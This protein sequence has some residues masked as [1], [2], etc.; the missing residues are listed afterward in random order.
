MGAKAETFFGI[1]GVGDLAT[2]CFSPT[3]RNRTCGEALGKGR[4][5]QQV[6]DDIPG[7]VEGVPTTKSVVELARRHQV[8]MPITL[9]IHAVLFEGLDPLEGIS[10]LMSRA[11]KAER[12]G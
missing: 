12:V 6:L 2:T 4:T 9:A 1:A 8:D 10:R 11:P 7:V 3:G 5:L